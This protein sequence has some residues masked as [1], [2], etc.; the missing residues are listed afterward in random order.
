VTLDEMLS[1]VMHMTS[2]VSVLAHIH[3]YMYAL[4]YTQ[5][6]TPVCMYVEW[7]NAIRCHQVPSG[8]I[9]Q[10]QEQVGT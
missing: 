7:M 10:D 1:S 3:T 6:C 8:A 2:E 4:I 9:K 5:M